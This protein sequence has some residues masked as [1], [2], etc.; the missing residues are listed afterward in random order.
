MARVELQLINRQRRD[1][2]PLAWLTRLTRCVVRRLGICEQG[3]L[4]VTFIESRTMRVL[5][6][7]FAQHEG[8]TDVLSFR[9]PGE[10]IVGEILVA[11]AFA[12]VYAK[13]HQVSYRQ[14][15]ARYVIH[16]LLHWVGHEDRTLQQQRRM[17]Q[18]EDRLLAQ[19]AR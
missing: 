2:V 18:M 19:C 10:P 16:G 11:P 7:R 1:A 8:L 6:R 17:R 14:E 13:H 3:Q 12:R 4:T 5:N 9:Y 15:L